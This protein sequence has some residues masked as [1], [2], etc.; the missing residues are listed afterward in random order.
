MELGWPAYAGAFA[1]SLGLSWFLTPLMLRLALHLQVFDEPAERKSHDSPVPYLGGVAIAG[2]FAVTVTAAAVSV[3]PGREVRALVILLLTGLLLAAVGLWDD[4]RSI[5]AGP[6]LVV[7]VAAGFVVWAVGSGSALP[8][9]DWLDLL[10]TLVWVV[11]VTNAFNLLDNMD[12]LSAGVAVIAAA[13]FFAIAAANGQYLIAAFAAALAGCAAGFLRHNFFPARIYMGDAGSLFIGFLLSVIGLRLRLIDAPRYVALFVP[14]VVLGVALF[15]TTLVTINRLRHGRSPLSG[16]RD[17]T[18]HRLVWVGLPVPVAVGLIYATA[19]T[20]GWL[21][22]LLS[23]LDQTSGLMLAGFV[24]VAGAC[25]LTVL[26]V[27]PVY[28][29]SRQRQSMLRLV[30]GHEVEP[31][32]EVAAS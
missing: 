9:P 8:G 16:G 14:V 15:D 22:L 19:L 25:G 26:S 6:R 24:V 28:E 21:G 31:D 20:L 5:G 29:N 12:G 2:A 7:E 10:V 3:G 17:H 32:S 11:G 1:V 30:R 13:S 18:S 4:L 23:R 27:V